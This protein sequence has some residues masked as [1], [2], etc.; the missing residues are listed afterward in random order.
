MNFLHAS[1]VTLLDNFC[2][3]IDFVMRRPNAWAELH[4]QL[5]RVRTETFSHL[6]DRFR[7]NRRLS[8]FFPGM[9][10]TDH[11]C[12]WIDNVNGTAIGHMNT[13]GNPFLVLD[14]SIAIREFSVPA[15]R[16]I[17]N[18]DFV[19]MNLLCGQKRP[20][21]HSN[22]STHLAMN[23]IESFQCFGFVV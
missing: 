20:F 11:R 4:N 2:G 19:S 1:C 12:F 22:F 13:K 17:D 6:L 21:C 8:P 9:D 15:Y 16:L 7:N 18:R 23:S 14:D 3:E 5:G 10:E